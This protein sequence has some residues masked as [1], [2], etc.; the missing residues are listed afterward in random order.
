MIMFTLRFFSS[1]RV[2]TVTDFLIKLGIKPCMRLVEISIFSL[3]DVIVRL[4]KIYEQSQHKLDIFLENKVLK[5]LMFSENFTC[6]S[7]SPSLLIIFIKKSESFVWFLI[8]K[9]EFESQNFAIFEEV[10]HNFDQRSDNIIIYSEKCLFPI[11]A[12]M[13]WCPTWSK[14]LWR[15]LL[16]RSHARRKTCLL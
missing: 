16:R 13:V 8:L 10:V 15:Y 11:D 6:K 2:D 5:E 14:N 7:W 4:T 3:N 1:C 9:T 12:Y